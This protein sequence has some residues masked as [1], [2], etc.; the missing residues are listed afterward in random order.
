MQ[1]FPQENSIVLSIRWDQDRTV[2]RNSQL[3][4]NYLFEPWK[5]FWFRPSRSQLE[6]SNLPKKV[7]LEYHWF[8]SCQ[9]YSITGNVK[10]VALF[11]ENFDLRIRFPQ[12]LL[13]W[14]IPSRSQ[15][16]TLLLSLTVSTKNLFMVRGTKTQKSEGK[17]EMLSVLNQFVSKTLT[18]LWKQFW[19]FPLGYQLKTS[20]FQQVICL[21]NF[22]FW[23]LDQHPYGVKVSEIAVT[24]SSNRHWHS[25][26]CLT[27]HLFRS[28]MI[29]I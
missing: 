8:V 20:Q 25:P 21:R 14:F 17:L 26:L 15:T 18:H 5:Q 10:N 4:P 1:K 22:S 13:K 29:P 16:K 24:N 28:I 23:S 12:Q 7:F 19:Y 3:G 2:L 6:S 11:Q 27:T 9:G